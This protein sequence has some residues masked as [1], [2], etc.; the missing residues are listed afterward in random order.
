V[1]VVI[2]G[3]RGSDVEAFMRRL[4]WW[5][6]HGHGSRVSAV[7]EALRLA[8][9]ELVPEAVRQLRTLA[10]ER[11][12]TPSRGGGLSIFGGG[13]GG[14]A[15]HHGGSTPNDGLPDVFFDSRV[16]RMLA[17]AFGRIPTAVLAD[18]DNV[19]M[20]HLRATLEQLCSVWLREKHSADA[21]TPSHGMQ[22]PIHGHHGVHHGGGGGGVLAGRVESK[23]LIHTAGLLGAYFR[24]I[25][26]RARERERAASNAALLIDDKEVS[27]KPSKQVAKPA[28]LS[29]VRNALELLQSW[30][31]LA[32]LPLPTAASARGSKDSAGGSDARV[33]VLSA[34]EALLAVRPL[35]Q[36]NADDPEIEKGLESDVRHFL[37]ALLLSAPVL[38]PHVR[39]ALAAHLRHNGGHDGRGLALFMRKSLRGAHRS[40][41]G[42]GVD[43]GA[44]ALARAYFSAIVDCADGSGEG[45]YDGGLAAARQADARIS[46]QLL[47]LALLHQGAQDAPMRELGARLA[48][49]ICPLSHEALTAAPHAAAPHAAIA[50]GPAPTE[51]LLY[52]ASAFRYSAALAAA[53]RAHEGLPALLSVLVERFTQLSL[54]EREDALL[55]LMPWLQTFGARTPQLLADDELG[56]S[57]LN[58]ALS[59]YFALTRLCSAAA[60]PGLMGETAQVRFLLE[61]G[62]AALATP[63][64]APMFATVLHSLLLDAHM[65]AA[66]PAIDTHEQA[67]CVRVLLLT[68]R[69]PAAPDLLSAL[70]GSLRAYGPDSPSW[71]RPASEWLAWRAPRVSRARPLTPTELSAFEMLPALPHEVPAL[72]RPHLPTLLHTCV[73]CHGGEPGTDR[74]DGRSAEH[75]VQLLDALVANL[76]P[77]GDPGQPGRRLE[78]ACLSMRGLPRGLAAVRPLVLRLGG[79]APSLARDWRALS[80]CW[81]LH[82]EDPDLSLTSLRVF[83]LLNTQVNPELL[84]ALALA[85]WGALRDDGR[86]KAQLLLRLMIELPPLA[87]SP[88]GERTWLLLAETAAALLASRAAHLFEEAAKLLLATLAAQGTDG[89]SEVMLAKLAEVWRGA[90][91]RGLP[92]GAEHLRRP[93]EEVLSHLLL[94][95]LAGEEAS[96]E[97]RATTLLALETLAEDYSD[98]MPPN[99]R[100]VIAVLF[101]HTLA[102]MLGQADAAPR[103]AAFLE[104]CGSALAE[105]LLDLFRSTKLPRAVTE[106]LRAAMGPARGN[107]VVSGD[108]AIDADVADV[109]GAFARNFAERFFGAFALAFSSH[110]NCDFALLLLSSWLAAGCPWDDHRPGGRARTTREVALL[111]M[112][113]GLLRQ[114]APHDV[115]PAQFEALAPLVVAAFHSRRP[116]VSA[117]AE[118]LL[119]EMVARAPRGTPP[120]IFA[121]TAAKPEPQPPPWCGPLVSA[122]D[123]EG[124]PSLL[125]AAALLQVHALGV[126]LSQG[127]PPLRDD[128]T[129]ALAAVA[130][131]PDNETTHASMLDEESEDHPG[132]PVLSNAPVPLSSIGVRSSCSGSS[133][134]TASLPGTPRSRASL[135]IVSINAPSPS[136]SEE[137]GP[138]SPNSLQ[139]NTPNSALQ[140]RP[141][142]TVAAPVVHEEDEDDDSDLVLSCSSEDDETA[143]KA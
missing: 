35:G 89:P 111:W 98:L 14:A 77:D 100:L 138:F 119:S 127:P 19:G 39:R 116:S 64:N 38:A 12:E 46:A 32:C 85:L 130:Q 10:T 82:A 30:M 97:C 80:L 27:E 34:L 133:L 87:D 142:A 7:L 96:A 73:V 117:A 81:A 118:A 33:V 92:P 74:A 57:A 103:A 61:A 143:S 75:A 76:A 128:L 140:P 72:L 43:A 1:P 4:V 68:L 90:E 2:G 120:S 52:S 86:A 88:L 17:E 15:K 115:A 113:Q 47:L 112:L 95:G 114:F 107:A 123:E 16:L 44:G 91:Q 48:R 141:A 26:L 79:V 131:L 60:S 63:A 110:D 18:V 36:P 109:M 3:D 139:G 37:D 51:P 134:P 122:G 23:N 93:L 56:T 22:M 94:K 40:A 126:S 137:S 102:V 129:P 21:T 71:D 5:V 108:R 58:T 13:G 121:L 106:E 105:R 136:A 125:A 69:T 42:A 53:P 135:S 9:I 55:L 29:F 49:A 99:N 65:T 50:G 83:A 11:A 6:L 104:R 45:G 66:E 101:C 41:G 59:L 124:R 84:H 62:W 20:S 132:S 67:L 31:S 25:A 70:L 24:L 8:H 54:P 28:S 78:R